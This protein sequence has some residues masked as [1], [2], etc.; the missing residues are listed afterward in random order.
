MCLEQVNRRLVEGCARGKEA[1][2]GNRVPQCEQ[3]GIGQ[4]S[5]LKPFDVLQIQSLLE[6][7]MDESR[8]TPVLEFDRKPIPQSHDRR[9]TLP[10]DSE[11]MIHV[12]HVVISHLQDEKWPR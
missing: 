7:W 1:I 5:F 11:T 8:E 3:L 9:R 10:N 6:V 12:P 2:V 4:A